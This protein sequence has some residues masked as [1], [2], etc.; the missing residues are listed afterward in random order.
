MTMGLTKMQAD[1][2]GYI[3]DYRA[4]HGGVSPSYQEIA[5][6]L[7]IKSK[8][9]VT[10]LI[11]KLIERGAVRRLA[12]RSRSIVILD[13]GTTCPHCGEISGSQACIANARRTR[14]PREARAVAMAGAG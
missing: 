14:T 11:E 6:T 13:A 3:K 1:C 8:S 12:R 7:Q 4:R 10:R 2:L 5:A 9:G